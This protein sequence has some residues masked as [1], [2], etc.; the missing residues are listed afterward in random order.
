MIAITDLPDLVRGLKKEDAEVF[1]RLYR[2]HEDEGE[3]TFP[4]D[5]IGWADKT[6]G[7]H[8]NVEKQKIVKTI[9]RLTF[10]GALF[11]D[12]RS[13][14]PKVAAEKD[15]KELEQIK[16]S[17]CD[18][19]CTPLKM[20]PADTFGR[21]S[22]RHSESA[23]NVAKYDAL[24]GL[25][26]FKK[27]NPLDFTEKEVQDHI[28]TANKWIAVA[29]RKNPFAKYPFVLW[30][31]LWRAGASVIHGH[32]QMLLGR[33]EHY[34]EV[35]H[36]KK[37]RSE[38][39][40]RTGREYFDD[41]Y[42][43]HRA[44]S[45]GFESK[46]IKVFCSIT[47]KKDKEITLIGEKLD[48]KMASA[49]YKSAKC[50]TEDFG[51]GSFNVAVMMPP[52]EEKALFRKREINEWTGFPVVARI[53]DRGALANKTTDVAGMEMYSGSVVVETDP[54]RVIEKLKERF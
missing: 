29:H 26:I 52:I 24:H 33:H 5:M 2:V 36:Y 46:R 35:E 51:A 7:D 48:S 47:P 19:F 31:C 22:G 41:M 10:E 40:A 42:L 4:K 44:I 49:I 6:F 20:T 54:Y 25:V 12:L 38:Y 13:K 34:A 43:A 39:N 11:N 8:A 17:G 28:A 1:E 45:L 37:V 15:D 16:Q 3:L 21:V 23:S 14:R 18:P 9:N 32:M 50:L 30:N 27:H 53:V